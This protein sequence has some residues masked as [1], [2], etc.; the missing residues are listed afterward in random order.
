VKQTQLS[1]ATL[2]RLPAYLRYLKQL[3]AEAVCTVSAT[4]IAKALGYGEVLVRKDLA[5]VSGAGKPKVGYVTCELVENLERTLGAAELTRAVIVG[6]GRLGRALLG[7]KGFEEFGL[8]ICAAFDTDESVQGISK[9][10]KN[11][12]PMEKFESY[13]AQ[14]G[15]RIG[16]ITV[17]AEAAQEVCN[18][19]VKNQI[20]AIWSFAPGALEVPEGV[21]VRQEN[22]AL[23]LAYLNKQMNC[24]GRF[25]E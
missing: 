11:I 23:S 7:Y 14:R 21:I 18:L 25:R 2:G 22:L 1:K 17:P 9:S 24:P 19:M 5:A 6:A 3:D 8:E 16:I 4:A 13:C 15:I 12:F 10:G 20:G